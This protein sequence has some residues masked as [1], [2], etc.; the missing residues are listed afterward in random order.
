MANG[1]TREKQYL[2]ESYGYQI[3][4]FRCVADRID[5]ICDETWKMG[6]DNDLIP[7]ARIRRHLFE[8][9]HLH[10]SFYWTKIQ[11]AGDLAGE[12]ME[13]PSAK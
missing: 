13:Q 4:H 11:D 9:V 8:E 12:S 5:K 3:I 7:S 10:G 2:L 1:N 6:D